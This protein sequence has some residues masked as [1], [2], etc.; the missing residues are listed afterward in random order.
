MTLACANPWRVPFKISQNSPRSKNHSLTF[1][2][3]DKPTFNRFSSTEETVQMLS[4]TIL[5][6]MLLAASVVMSESLV[7]RDAEVGDAT[8][9]Y[10]QIPITRHYGPSLLSKRAISSQLLKI[11]PDFAGYTADIQ[12]GTPPQTLSLILDTGSPLTWATNTNI[13][14]YTPPGMRAGENTTFLRTEICKGPAGCFNPTQSS[15][16]ILPSNSTVFDI[17]YVDRSAAVGRTIADK[18]SFASLSIN[19]FYWGLVA[20]QYNPQRMGA[21]S[22]IIGLSPSTAVASYPSFPDAISANN[23]TMGAFNAPTLLDQMVSAGVINSPAYSLFLD[24]NNTGSLLLGGVDSAKFTGPLTVLPIVQPSQASLQVQLTGIGI[25]RSSSLAT[26]LSNTIVVLDSGTTEI[27]LPTNAVNHIAKVLGGT[28][29][30]GQPI[31]DCAIVR[32][33]TTVDFYF[34]NKG[35]IRVPLN[36]LVDASAPS[37]R[38]NLCRLAIVATPADSYFLLGDFFLRSAYVVYNFPQQQIAIAQASYNSAPANIKAITSDKQ[39]IPG[40]I[41][42]AASYTGSSA[43]VASPAATGFIQPFNGASSI[44]GTAGPATSTPTTTAA[45]NS[46]KNGARRHGVPLSIISCLM[47]AFS[48]ALFLF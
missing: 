47:F 38:Q 26:S 28:T 33:S 8:D 29:S 30:G 18:A 32:A 2:S 22:G 19:T 34:P 14:A 45:P 44:I 3:L 23:Q 36:Q 25:N 21:P 4:S 12:I 7:K 15:T 42:D 9:K 11:T 46:T 16:F 17:T 10:V 5:H 37:R 24:A 39:G 1:D 13:S 35:L 41:Y 40:G 31:V 20:Y 43:V 48:G 27:Y 6:A